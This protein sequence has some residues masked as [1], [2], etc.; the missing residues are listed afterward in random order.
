[1]PA[2]AQRA[3]TR[4]GLTNYNFGQK[5]CKDMAPGIRVHKCACMVLHC[6]A[7]FFYGLLWLCMFLCGLAQSSMV[8]V[9]H[10]PL[11]SVVVQSGLVWSFFNVIKCL[12]VG[13][14]QQF[15]F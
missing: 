4:N 1:M 7:W 10:C 3:G 15:L 13:L 2:L 12:F 5:M 8:M 11:C 14:T 9:M 6:P